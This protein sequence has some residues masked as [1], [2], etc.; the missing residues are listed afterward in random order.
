MKK[1]VS[2]TDVAKETGLSVTTV[3]QILNGKGARFSEKSRKRV[4]AAKEA[5]GYEPDLFARGLVASAATQS[6][7]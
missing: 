1:K 2:I 7:S 6:G 5:L 3:S 4:L